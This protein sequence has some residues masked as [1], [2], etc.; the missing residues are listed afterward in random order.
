[1]AEYNKISQDNKVFKYYKDLINCDEKGVKQ[2][3]GRI[4]R[5]LVNLTEDDLIH[6]L[7]YNKYEIHKIHELIKKC[8]IINHQNLYY[9]DE[10]KLWNV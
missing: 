3:L 5:V 9:S 2:K 8:G 10:N 4:A 7:F 6:L 1:M